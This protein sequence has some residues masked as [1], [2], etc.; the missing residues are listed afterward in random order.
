MIISIQGQQNGRNN[1]I[2][3]RQRSLNTFVFRL[4]FITQI[5]YKELFDD[6][7][8]SLFHRRNSKRFLF[9]FKI[10][11]IKSD[12]IISSRDL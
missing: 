2:L 10:L 4:F 9:L 7:V 6:G 11:R 12:Y 5:Y 8:L 3:N 1:L